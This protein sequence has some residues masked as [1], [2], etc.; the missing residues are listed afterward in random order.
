MKYH[1]HL[2]F[3]IRYVML[4]S[5]DKHDVTTN[6]DVAWSPGLSTGHSSSPFLSSIIPQIVLQPQGT[7]DWSLALFTQHNALEMN[8]RRCVPSVCFCVFLH[9]LSLGACL[10]NHSSF[11]GHLNDLKFLSNKN[12]D[13]I[14]IHAW[15]FFMLIWVNVDYCIR[16]RNV[17]N[18][19]EKT[20]HFPK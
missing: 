13:T 20:D 9:S 3:H 5:F 19:L 1:C 18:L 7:E 11:K 2:K 4:M 17:F 8:L 15:D 14:N 12:K 6:Q 10:L 16:S